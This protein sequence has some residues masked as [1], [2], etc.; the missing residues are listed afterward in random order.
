MVIICL[1]SFSQVSWYVL[2]PNNLV[3]RELDIRGVIVS[4]ITLFVN[5]K[6][7]VTY[8]YYMHWC[9]ILKKIAKLTQFLILYTGIQVLGIYVGEA[10]GI[11]W[12]FY[13]CV[14]H[15]KW[16]VMFYKICLRNL[17][18]WPYTNAVINHNR[19]IDAGYNVHGWASVTLFFFCFI[20]N[21]FVSISSN[22]HSIPRILSHVP[23]MITAFTKKTEKYSVPIRIPSLALWVLKARTFFVVFVSNEWSMLY[24][25]ICNILE[26]KHPF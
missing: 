23:V 9:F 6:S 2:N 21:I 17:P 18:N 25:S 7:T 8:K 22:A 15:L 5:Q 4:L 10:K 13:W 24:V 16:T 3:N 19:Y 14:D 1:N 26:R 11:N 20:F 12:Q